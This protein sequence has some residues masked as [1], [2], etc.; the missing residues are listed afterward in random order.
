M[1]ARNTIGKMAK[2]SISYSI[3]VPIVT[4]IFIIISL[5][6]AMPAYYVA[7][8]VFGE[9]GAAYAI[10]SIV[11]VALGSLY[12]DNDE[13]VDNQLDELQ[14]ELGNLGITLNKKI[15]R[16]FFLLGAVFFVNL[17]ILV[18]TFAVGI[19]A[20]EASIGLGMVMVMF[21]T[22]LDFAIADQRETSI[23]GALASLPV[24]FLIFTAGVMQMLI[25]GEESVIENIGGLTKSILRSMPFWE[26]RK[27]SKILSRRG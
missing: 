21:I 27:D 26:I 7:V 5:V 23:I 4:A 6:V 1:V 16:I 19:L 8:S 13:E 2:L 15:L 22:F 25:T 24:V 12:L 20:S 18:P 17:L 10:A 9:V 14:E 11:A 3:A